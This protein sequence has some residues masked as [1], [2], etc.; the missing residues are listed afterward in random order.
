MK[1]VLFLKFIHYP[2]FFGRTRKTK[3]DF[4]EIRAIFRFFKNLAWISVNSLVCDSCVVFL[5][6]TKNNE[7]GTSVT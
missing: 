3:F 5:L 2:G 1:D 6:Q 7:I 4:V